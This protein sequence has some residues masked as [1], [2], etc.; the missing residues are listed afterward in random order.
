MEKA[1]VEK[2]FRCAINQ[3]VELFD[4]F[5]NMEDNPICSRHSIPGDIVDEVQPLYIG[6]H[7]L[8]FVYG[9]FWQS[10]VVLVSTSASLAF[11]NLK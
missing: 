3:R 7:Q 8:N 11:C 6:P 9:Q 5:Q 1:V 4:I 10:C 2:P